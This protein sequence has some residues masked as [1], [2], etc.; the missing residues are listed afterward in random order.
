MT[1]P[2]NRANGG[3]LPTRLTRWHHVDDSAEVLEGEPPQ[4][5]RAGTLLVRG[6]P[7]PA[8]EQ[9][10]ESAALV[11]HEQSGVE[12]DDAVTVTVRRSGCELLEIHG[13]M[14]ASRHSLVTFR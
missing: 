1:T 11:H 2:H 6:V 3:K 9:A 13:A 4:T 14:L 5:G 12:G 8:V 10:V 7:E